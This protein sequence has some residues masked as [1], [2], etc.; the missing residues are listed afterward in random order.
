VKKIYGPQAIGTGVALPVRRSLI[1]RRVSVELARR[2]KNTRH[3]VSVIACTGGT[4]LMNVMPYIDGFPL[5]SLRASEWPKPNQLRKL[6]SFF[7]EAERGFGTP[8]F[9]GL[10]LTSQRL[11]TIIRLYKTGS[12]A[13]KLRKYFSFGDATF[14]NILSTSEGLY[15]LDFEFAHLSDGGFDIGMLIAEIDQLIKR[16]M[17]LRYAQTALIQGYISG[18]GKLGAVLT[19]RARLAKFQAARTKRD[20]G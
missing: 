7:A 20:G 15:L 17:P 8:L 12:T 16:G 1:E 6:G 19:W 13:V 3:G 9:R 18:G 2:S 4:S 14:A 10:L 11:G 5:R